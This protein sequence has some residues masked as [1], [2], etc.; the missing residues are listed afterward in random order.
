M[1]EPTRQKYICHYTDETQ[2]G[3][4]IAQPANGEGD[5]IHFDT[6]A[7][8]ETFGTSPEIELELI[9]QEIPA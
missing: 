4:Y 7:E 5:P 1:N 2:P 3:G 8:L 9:K 6:F